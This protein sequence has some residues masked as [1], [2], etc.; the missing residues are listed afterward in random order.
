[1][2]VLPARSQDLIPKCYRPLMTDPN[3]PILDFYPDDC[4]IDLNG[5]RNAWEAIVLL[6]FVDVDKL[7]EAMK[8]YNELLTPE[9]KLVNSYGTDL[10]FRFN[11]QYNEHVSSPIPS[12]FSDFESHCI[13][14]IFKLPSMEGKE[15]VFGLIPHAKTG[16]NLRAGFPT[17]E[18]ISYTADLIAAGVTIFQQPSRSTSIIL[19]LENIHEGLTVD[20]FAK[21]YV[22]KIVY[23]NWPYLRES[24]VV[25]VMDSQMKFE[26]IETGKSR[27]KKVV[28]SPL[29]KFESDNFEKNRRDLFNKCTR[30]LGLRFVS[31]E[32]EDSGKQKHNGIP[33]PTPEPAIINYG[34]SA[35][36]FE[37]LVELKR[38][39]GL[40]R[41]KDGAYVKTFDE[42]S[43]LMPIQLI[44]NEVV[45]KDPRY[46]EKEPVPIEEEFPTGSEVAF[47]GAF[48]Y[49]TSGK[50]IGHENG[51]LSLK[52]TKIPKSLEPRFGTERARY[53]KQLLVYHPSVEVSKILGVNR[54]FLSRITSSFMIE[55]PKGR[56]YNFGLDLKFD[57]QKLKVLGYAKHA[58]HWWEYSDIAIHLIQDYKKTFPQLF[59]SLSNLQGNKIPSAKELFQISDPEKLQEKID[60]VNSY[61]KEK[62]SSFVTVSLG[63][64]SL[65]KPGIAHIEEK[66]IEYSTQ[67]QQISEKA[68]KGIPRDAILDTSRSFEILRKQVFDLGDRVEYIIDSGN[69]PI[70]SK[71][72][73]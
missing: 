60:Q 16:I 42:E 73:V 18:T 72:E 2:S 47:L 22:G 61:L 46:L 54:L 55:S 40:A 49:G 29:E 63:S 21:Q 7:L 36:V 25:S 6:S 28:S 52:I 19:T 11:P 50:V 62:K 43:T 3:S 59:K 70:Y 45:N 5:K 35:K 44:V 8:P 38:V 39:R 31:N 71:E 4:P 56:R 12:A 53:E 66:I 14:S 48:A 67:P 41:T 10:L 58:E 9:E 51:K 1:M 26:E 68:I 30:S 17:L 33:S 27:V 32:D 65:T 15:Y 20:Q 69:I 64:D 57:R 23:S 24:K 37:G 13:E 34:K